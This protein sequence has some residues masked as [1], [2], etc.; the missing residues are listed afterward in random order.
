[1]YQSFLKRM[2]QR[3]EKRLHKVGS[4]SF[5]RNILKCH[6]SQSTQAQVT[7]PVSFFDTNRKLAVDVFNMQD[8]E[9]LYEP[10][11]LRTFGENRTSGRMSPQCTVPDV[12]IGSSTAEFLFVFSTY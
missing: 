11:K 7:L 6:E 8:Q 12:N 2:M 9:D 5:C 1:M 4:N 3:N 10:E